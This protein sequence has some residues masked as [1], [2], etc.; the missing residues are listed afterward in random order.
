MWRSEKSRVWREKGSFCHIMEII[1]PCCWSR[2]LLDFY[3]HLSEGTAHCFHMTIPQNCPDQKPNLFQKALSP[4]NNR[5]TGSKLDNVFFFLD[6]LFNSLALRLLNAS[7]GEEKSRTAP[8]YL[9]FNYGSVWE[10][11][12]VERATLHLWRDVPANTCM[13]MPQCQ[14]SRAN[15]SLY[16]LVSVHFRAN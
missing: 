16:F 3:D 2:H 6:Y 11:W 13:Q 8:F 7:K 12:W 5:K 4:D 15:Y 1:V 9:A 10:V 14:V